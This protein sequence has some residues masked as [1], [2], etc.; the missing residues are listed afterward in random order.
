MEGFFPPK[1]G[2]DS[3]AG[4]DGTNGAQGAGAAPRSRDSLFLL[5]RLVFAG[6]DESRDVRVRN[7]SA[8]GLMA[9]YDGR[10]AIGDAVTV[11]LRGIGEVEGKVAWAA[12]GRIGIALDSQID[13]KKAR[14]PVVVRTR[15]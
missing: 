2:G 3:L 10:C 7:L 6:S 5:A 12:E 11:T 13:P 4:D 8:G 14:K 9:E 15:G 1:A